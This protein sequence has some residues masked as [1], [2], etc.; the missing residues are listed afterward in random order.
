MLVDSNLLLEESYAKPDTP[1]TDVVVA[2]V[3]CPLSLNVITA[4]AEPTLAPV[5]TLVSFAEAIAPVAIDA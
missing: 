2:L 5:T 4:V 3:I 1:A